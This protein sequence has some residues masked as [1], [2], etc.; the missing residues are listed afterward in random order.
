[1]ADQTFGRWAFIVGV[2]LAVIAGVVPA[3]QIETWVRFVLV[4][5]GA[6][7]GLMNVTG[8]ETQEFLIATVALLLAST[9]GALPDLGVR[10]SLVLTNIIAFVS[11][12]AIV[13]ALKAIYDLAKA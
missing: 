13:V 12:A 3:L 10:V 4:L 2:A 11:P 7:V 6:I 5:L 8:K 1:M 9:A